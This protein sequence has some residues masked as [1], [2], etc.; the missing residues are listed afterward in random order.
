MENLG[1]P[2][3]VVVVLHMV[4]NPDVN[5]GQGGGGKRLGAGCNNS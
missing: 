2:V 3:V 4:V 1:L 5:G